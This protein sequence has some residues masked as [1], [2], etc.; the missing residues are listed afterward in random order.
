VN[1]GQ[2]LENEQQAP[3]LRHSALASSNTVTIFSLCVVSL[4]FLAPMQLVA[5]P[6]R[7]GPVVDP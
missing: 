5:Q 2:S 7:L 6:D 3:Q 1:L 4:R